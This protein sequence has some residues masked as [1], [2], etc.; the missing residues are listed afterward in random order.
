[1][2]Q[3]LM[4]R[5]MKGIV[6]ELL[7]VTALL[8]TSAP[9]AVQADMPAPQI[10][11]SSGASGQTNQAISNPEAAGEPEAPANVDEDTSEPAL[12][13]FVAT[14]YCLRGKTSAGIRVN[15]G[16]VAADPTVLPIGSVIRLHAGE[17]SGIYTVLDTGPKLRGRRLD[18]WLPSY[19][20]AVQF[21]VRKVKVE[22]IRYGWDPVEKEVG[23]L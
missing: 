5:D 13:H 6:I 12:H 23:S 20:E 11:P 9:T 4:R 18:I 15:P 16:S 3:R 22:I 7:L 21:G 10:N 19:E 1:M 2:R 8:L 14:A 17:Y